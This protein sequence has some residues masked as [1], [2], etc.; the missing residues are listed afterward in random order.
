V[1]R[2]IQPLISLDEQS[3]LED[4]R[5]TPREEHPGRER[6]RVRD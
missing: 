5:K 3:H 6:E 2:Q 1:R 4:T